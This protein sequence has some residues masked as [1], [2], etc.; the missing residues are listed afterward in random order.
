MEVEGELL[1]KARRLRIS[2]VKMLYDAGSGHAAG[3]MGM[4]DVFTALYFGGILKY[5][6]WEPGWEERD[7]LILS[8][9]HICPI[10][11]ATL[12]EVGYFPKEELSGLRKIDSRLQGHPYANANK[13]S[14]SSRAE[15]GTPHG[16][17]HYV[18]NDITTLPGVEV[19][20]G[21]LGQGFSTGVGMALALKM[22]VKKPHVFII[23][24][25]GE[26]DEGQTWEAILFA[27]KYKLFNLTIILDR[28]GIQIGGD[29][30]TVMP[31][32][33]LALKY[34]SFNFNVVEVDG[35]NTPE[36][37]RVVGEVREAQ[38]AMQM[39][40]VVICHTIPG[41]GVSFMEGDYKWH[42]RVPNKEEAER[43]IKE[44]QIA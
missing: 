20:S 8:N 17:S 19:T 16:I 22:E 9:G 7:R 21:P 11:Y 41:K 15:R 34:K 30:E 38:I 24:S 28:N 14:L 12:S 2:I 10:L 23:S 36:I 31:L 37:I 1:E 29:T 13:N 35:H 39:P 40:G 3:A 32:E 4:A 27:A 43:A 44:L 6:P 25:D 42:G 5:R 26:H 18:R 33:S